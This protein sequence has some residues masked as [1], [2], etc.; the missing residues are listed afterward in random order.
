VLGLLADDLDR[1]LVGTDGPVGAEAV[2]DRLG[3]TGEGDL[4][5]TLPLQRRPAHVV[6]DADGEVVLR[7]R[8]AEVLEH[9]A[10]H[11]RIELLRGQSVPPAHDRGHRTPGTRLGEG[12]HHVEVERLAGGTRLLGPVEH[13]QTADRLRYRLEECLGRKGPVEADLE[14]ANPLAPGHEPVD[15][16]VRNLGA[17][18]HDHHH[19]LG[20]GVAIVVHEVVPPPGE[21][22]E[23]VHLQLHDLGALGV[24]GI[25]RL[26][27]LEEGVGILGGAAQDRMLGVERA[28]PV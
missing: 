4:E 11:P 21:L 22:G 9:R 16:L 13:R 26:A 3:P 15:G 24:E 19:P 6:D 25:A 10:N 28:R 17:R 5:V 7:L 18:A 8:A 1:R 20:L 12:G 27:S 23:T 2:E 14:H